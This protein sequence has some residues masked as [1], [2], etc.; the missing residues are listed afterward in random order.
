MGQHVCMLW[1]LHGSFGA[2]TWEDCCGSISCL[3]SCFWQQWDLNV[4]S[5]CY[6]IPSKCIVFHAAVRQPAVHANCS[7]VITTSTSLRLFIH[8]EAFLLLKFFFYWNGWKWL[9]H[10]WD[11]HNVNKEGESKVFLAMHML[12][13]FQYCLFEALGNINMNIWKLALCSCRLSVMEWKLR[14]STLHPIS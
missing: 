8:S 3:G 11:P 5:S 4:V 10:G 13:E 14:S 12:I 7:T 9:L 6:S 1:C 2:R